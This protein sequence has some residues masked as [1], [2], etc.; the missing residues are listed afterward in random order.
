M[1]RRT[2]LKFAAGTTGGLALMGSYPLIAGQHAVRINRYR[3]TLPRLPRSFDGFTIV[4]LTDLHYGY[5]TS[6]DLMQRVLSSA[7]AIPHDLTVCTGDYI[8]DKSAQVDELWPLICELKA[9]EGVFSVLGNHD[10]GSCLD[11]SRYWLEKSGQNIRRAVRKIERN[12]ETLWFAGA[13]DYWWDSFSID[14]VLEPI[15]RNECRILLAHNPDSAD[16]VAHEHADLVISGH[17]HGGQINLPFIGSPFYS[18]KNKAF[19]SG[20]CRSTRGFPVF[21]SKGIGMTR[22]P[23]RINCDPEIA[24]LE[25]R[26]A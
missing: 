9:P 1:N 18:V 8:L 21:I 17:T 20:L 16:T 12:G 23:V 26:K 24:I 10:H 5:F 19:T 7:N 13:G 22:I 2:F 3:I 25:L 6:L 11:R 14:K 15:P 4:Q